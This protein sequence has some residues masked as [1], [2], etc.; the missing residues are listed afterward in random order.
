MPCSAISCDSPPVAIARVKLSYQGLWPKSMSRGI[1]LATFCSLGSHSC[2]AEQRNRALD[3][4]LG[5][6]SE[7]AQ[8]DLARCRRAKT[9]DGDGVVREALPT[10]AH[11][12]LDGE[13][14]P[15]RRQHVLA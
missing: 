11:A 15:F 2:Q 9:I 10:E 5:I 12:G 8:H 3:D 6:D 1:A 4:M 13:H 7:L 14:R